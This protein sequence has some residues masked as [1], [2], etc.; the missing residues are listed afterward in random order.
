MDVIATAMVSS[1][2]YDVDTACA[3][4]RAGLTRSTELPFMVLEDDNSPGLAIGHPVPLL[5]GGFEGDARLIR[6]LEGALRDLNRRIPPD[7]LSSARAGFYLALPATTREHEGIDLIPEEDRGD[8]LEQLGEPATIDEVTRGRWI[9]GAALSMADFPE[10]PA[11]SVDLVQVALSGHTAVIELYERAQTDLGSGRISMAIVAAVDSLVTGATLSWLDAT[12]RLKG[13]KCPA[14]LS[15]GEAAAIVVLA[16]AEVS[17][18]R[19]SVRTIIEPVVTLPS[20]TRFLAA[21]TADGAGQ[22]EVLRALTT[23]VESSAGS[24]WLILDQNGEV[25][26]ATDWGRTL[27]RYRATNPVGNAEPTIWYPAGSFG[28]TGAAAGAVATCMAIRAHERGYSPSPH[29]IVMTNSDGALRG[30]CVVSAS[31]E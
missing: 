2:G 26:R 23:V 17:G 8:Y 9:L 11:S 6:L 12:Y 25:F 31:E 19:G 4:A 13:A 10:G 14:G 28:D 18:Q 3:A 22:F 16:N 27:V 21:E 30:G 15:P 24:P 20:S 29:A 7:L 5:G 1:L